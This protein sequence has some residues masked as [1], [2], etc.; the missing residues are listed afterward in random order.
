MFLPCWLFGLRKSNPGVCRPFG[1][2]NGFCRGSCQWV[3]PRAAAASVPSPGA[4]HCWPPPLQKTLQCRS[5]W[6]S[7]FWGHCFSPLAPGTHE[8]W[9]APSK[10][11]VSVSLSPVEA[12]QIKSQ[13]TFFW[14]I[15][16]RECCIFLSCKL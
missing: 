11:G 14:R 13:N 4:S 3:L 5:V 16:R 1:G 8:T 15:S 2:A 9:C 12:L 7:L 6:P 10:S